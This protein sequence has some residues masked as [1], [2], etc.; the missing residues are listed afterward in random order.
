MF[1]GDPLGLFGFGGR[2]YCWYDECWRGPGWYWCGYGHRYGAGWGG[3]EGFQGWGERRYERDWRRRDDDGGYGED[4]DAGSR[5][6]YDGP[7][8]GE[9]RRY[10]GPERGRFDRREGGSNPAG[11]EPHGG[12]QRQGGGAQ[13]NGQQNRGGGGPVNGAPGDGGQRRP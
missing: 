6:R 3:G 8:G 13:N 7:I 5:R 4:E 2:E 10:D 12:G 11:G 1:L 9:R